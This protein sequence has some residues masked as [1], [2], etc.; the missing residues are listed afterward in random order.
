[1][2]AAEDVLSRA[3]GAGEGGVLL[4]LGPPGIGKTAVLDALVDEA[5]GR[6]FVV[7]RS[8]A[9][10]GDQIAPMAQLLLALRAGKK[11]LLSDAAFAELTPLRDQPVWLIDRIIGALEERALQAPVLVVVDD[12]QWADRLTLSCL[13]IMPA[14]LTGSP[15]VWLLAARDGNPSID[16][17]MEARARDAPRPHVVRLAPLDDESIEAIAGDRLGTGPSANVRQLLHQAVGNPFLAVSLL[18]ALGDA[19]LTDDGSELPRR[20]KNGARRRLAPLSE[21]ALDL[22]QVGAVL[23]RPFALRDA[24]A[25]LGRPVLADLRGAVDEAVRERVLQDDS[26]LLSFTHDLVRQAVYDEIAPS[27]R[28]ELHRLIVAHLVES[29]ASPL[30]AVPHVLASATTGDHAAVLL[31]VRA[32]TSVVSSMPAVAADVILRALAL[33]SESDQ[34]WLDVGRTAFSILADARRERDA[35]ALANRLGRLVTDPNKYATLQAA[36]AWPLWSMGRAEEMLSRIDT[37]WAREGISEPIRAELLS[38]RALGGSRGDDYEAAL[39]A[40]RSALEFSRSVG[41]EL[42]EATASRA[43]AETSMSDG[44]FADA[45]QYLRD[46][47][48][49]AESLKTIPSQILLL[50][51]IDRLD[52]SA[53]LLA[54]AQELVDR[55]AGIRPADVAYARL[56]QDY[57]AGN[58]DDAETEALTILREC[59][60]VHEDTY[61][62]EARLVLERVTQIRGRYDDA[63]RHIALA[64]ED[65]AGGD[66]TRTVLIAAATAWFHESRGDYA[67]ALPLVRDVMHPRCGV[68]HRWRN[69]PGWLVVAARCAVRGGDARLAAE[70]ESLAVGLAE[71]NPEV[72]TIVGSAEH[73]RGLVRRDVDALRAATGLLERSPRRYMFADAEADYGRAL[74]AD[75]RR[76]AGV[77]ALDR[78]WDRFHALGA[79]SAAEDVQRALAGTGVRRVRWASRKSKPL[80]GWDSLTRTEQRVARLIFQGHTNRS[81]ANVLSLSSHTVNS[82][83]RAIFGKLAV[84]SRIQLMRVL[85]DRLSTEQGSQPETSRV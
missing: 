82:H 73:I 25:F 80:T 63:E 26:G 8:K 22:A 4:V 33:L 66:E 16:T 30:D 76:D 39:T 3:S 10:E 54:H 52:E 70:I 67:R 21:T 71:R 47:R 57:T 32:A 68:R 2:H 13:R 49:P 78:A 15:V 72:A 60:E 65:I 7:G 62:V 17:L 35:L 84:N 53:A 37:A 69:L 56:W 12:V 28:N 38:L 29:G 75:G 42:A 45:L 20:L 48:S 81:A 40:G 77:A 36:A 18:D 11:P 1:M 43:L 50:Q 64:V 51:F 55:G 19:D 61:Q 59:D 46:I 5:E 31:L 27:F 79:A 85:M 74:L 58:F 83:L 14:R 23:G 6:G 41:S 44:R 24:A 34:M 9:D